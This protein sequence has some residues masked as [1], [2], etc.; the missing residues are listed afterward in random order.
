MLWSKRRSSRQEQHN[1]IPHKGSQPEQLPLPSHRQSIPPNSSPRPPLSPLDPLDPQ[2][3]QSSLV[4][5]ADHTSSD[6]SSSFHRTSAIAK[7][8][9]GRQVASCESVAAR[10]KM[11]SEPTQTK[12]EQN[13]RS[14]NP[15]SQ[16][17]TVMPSFE[18]P[19]ALTAD[20]YTY[21]SLNSFSFGAVQPQAPPPVSRSIHPLSTGHGDADSVNEDLLRGPDV[22]PRPSVVAYDHVDQFRSHPAQP[23]G[24]SPA[25]QTYT[26]NRHRAH[27]DR[28]PRHSGGESDTTSQRGVSSASASVTSLST[29][30]ADFSRAGSRASHHT[31]STNQTSA[32]HSSIDTDDDDDHHHPIPPGVVNA[33][34][35]GVRS[36]AAMEFSSDEEYS[37]YDD[38]YYDEDTGVN[39]EIGSAQYE[40]SV[41]TH[42]WDLYSGAGGSNGSVR[43]HAGFGS[44]DRRGSIPMAIPGSTSAIGFAD[45][46]V[47]SSGRNREDSLAT[48]RRPSRSLDDDFNKPGLGRAIATSISGETPMQHPLQSSPTSVPGS[49]GDWRILEERNKS[50]G[51]AREMNTGLAPSNSFG[52]NAASSTL[53]PDASFAAM[54][55]FDLDW[56]QMR[57]GIT[58]LDPNQLG[59]II[60]NSSPTSSSNERRP[61]TIGARWLQWVSKDARRPSTATVS[62]YGGDSFGKAIRNWD[63]P[64]YQA[65]RRDWSFKKE[66]VEKPYDTSGVVLRRA[67]TTGFLS[68]RGSMATER[69]GSSPPTTGELERAVVNEAERD[70][71]VSSAVWKGMRIDS[72]ELWRNDLVGRF[73]V[74]RRAAKPADESKGPQ[75]RLVVQRVREQSDLGAPGP[76]VTVHKHSKAIAFSI[77]RHYRP[78]RKRVD[79]PPTSSRATDATLTATTGAGSVVPATKKSSSMILLAPLRVQEAYTSTNTTRKLE[80]HG[81]LDD[82]VAGTSADARDKERLRRHKERE[83]KQKPKERPKTAD[84]AKVKGKGKQQSKDDGHIHSGSSPVVQSLPPP[85][86]SAP[87]SHTYP[88]GPSTSSS[89]LVGREAT[90]ADRAISRTSSHHS[91]RRR[92]IRDPLED[93]GDDD[94]DADGPPT[95]TPH[96]EAFGTMD[97][98]LI[99]QLRQ[100]R[101]Q[102]DSERGIWGRFLGRG[103]NTSAGSAAQIHAPFNPPWLALQPRNRQESHQGVINTLNDSFK[104]VGLLPSNYSTSR[105][106]PPASQRQKKIASGDD[107]RN[108]FRGIPEDS[109]YM[110]LPLW[111]GDTDPR[112]SLAVPSFERPV[113]PNNKRQYIL[114]YYKVPD[115]P[116]DERS[117]SREGSS[118]RSRTSPTSSYESGSKRDDRVSILLSSFHI[119]ARLVPYKDLQGTGVRIPDEGLAVTGPLSVAF[120]Q[121]PPVA[122]DPSKYEWVVGICHSREAGVE[123]YPDGLLKLGLCLQTSP[124]IVRPTSE[125]EEV[126][127]PDMKLTPIGKAVL[128]MVWLGA[129]ALTS[130]G[131]VA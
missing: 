84:D 110:L 14:P 96:S 50:K 72:T 30:S 34:A 8:A 81:L 7:Q 100:D 6:S 92:R 40:S 53:S 88:P 23:P 67:S 112:S 80:S 86:A 120:E 55:A 20:L 44:S 99:E 27:T 124:V 57:G 65:Q 118:K 95:R 26:Q 71:A 113:I 73:K 131:S 102:G 46:F 76:V 125:E 41:I 31:T 36:N 13:Q 101:H 42:D 117:K 64:R 89:S 60:G 83:Q 29:T 94:D 59:D 39:I 12:S 130:F 25:K 63:G 49:E 126:P 37:E 85:P 54:D 4:A 52:T 17:P 103:G 97:A 1:S 22:T 122:T 77:S 91:R 116:K 82:G 75:Q 56:A 114:V 33:I 43:A 38:E 16:S 123:F 45:P 111:P 69:T 9:I 128:E 90:V 70:K 5:T 78:P 35:R 93:D 121:M 108:P 109:L 11:P 32:D 107:D 24:Q 21:N 15:Y 58:T 3:S 127:D 68:P 104:D 74:D 98:A 62:S 119:T 19:T 129:L 48:L 2:G 18:T 105:H 87:S 47:F 79:V 66:R 10:R 115:T 61:S 28:H 106:A 51:K